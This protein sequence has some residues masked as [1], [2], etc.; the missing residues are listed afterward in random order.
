MN[1]WY[2]KSFLVFYILKN[3]QKR[4]IFSYRNESLL[5]GILSTWKCLYSF[6]TILLGTLK[7]FFVTVCQR[8]LHNRQFNA[9]SAW[10]P[11][12]V[13]TFSLSWDFLSWK[14][15]SSWKIHHFF[16][17]LFVC[18]KKRTMNKISIFPEHVFINGKWQKLVFNLF[19]WDQL[20]KTSVCPF[21]K[22]YSRSFEAFSEF[23][24][25]RSVLYEKD[26]FKTKLDRT[27]SFI[28][29]FLAEKKIFQIPLKKHQPHRNSSVS[30][31]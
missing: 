23:V 24:L 16:C 31:F 6:K 7:D 22:C 12:S 1:I 25:K 19:F 26:W 13:Q 10:Y 30:W 5:Q 11:N 18:S 17:F 29:A 14:L 20:L 8:H 27:T 28:K 4:I 2:C 3:W 9:L 15:S 21:Y